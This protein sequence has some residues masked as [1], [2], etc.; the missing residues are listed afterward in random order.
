MTTAAVGSAGGGNLGT[1]ARG[2][3]R[4]R[5][6][7]D[8]HAM[9]PDAEFGSYYGR[10]V[11]RAPQWEERDIA[12]YLFLGGL[13]AG[14]SML[15]AGAD[16]TGNAPLRRVGR[17]A[18]LAGIGVSFVA[19]VHDLGKPLRFLHML[20]VAKVTSPMSMG[21]WILMA[22][23]PMAGIAAGTEVL[24]VFPRIGRLAGFAAAGAAPLVA[25]YTAVLIGDTA[26]PTWH[27][28]FP[29][30]PLV[31]VGSASAAGAGVGL[32][33]VPVERAGPARRLALMGAVLELGAMEKMERRMGLVGEPLHL[34]RPGR[35]LKMSKGLTA[36]GALLGAVAG[37]RSR[38][39]A[40]AA[41][42]A[43]VAGSACTR[44]GV[45]AAGVESARDPKYTVIPQRE[46]LDSGNAARGR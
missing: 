46:R 45:F 20:R 6:R 10:P 36:G 12:G 23:G 11:V 27:E 43:L 21:T 40:M 42:A 38:V 35:L 22:Y 9:V 30:L 15:A 2:G 33:A 41:G 24:K 5:R 1:P 3:G 13:A 25:S 29:E 39:A 28:A 7:R 32:L 14:S 19:L 8:E 17:L 44:F 26:V 34:G 37:R 31:F 16:A 4:R 18:G